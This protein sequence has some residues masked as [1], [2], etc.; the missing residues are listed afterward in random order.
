[1]LRDVNDVDLWVET[2]GDPADPPVLLIGLHWPDEL[3]DQLTG[4]YVVR[5][6]LRDT[7]R[8]A[9]DDP[10]APKYDLRDLV[11]DAAGLSTGRRMWWG[12]GSADSSRNCSPWSTRSPR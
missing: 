8:S 2:F 3:V 9:Y 7:G 1:M 12:W 11:A 6:D 4:R 5:Y 10:D